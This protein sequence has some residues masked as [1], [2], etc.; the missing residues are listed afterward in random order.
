MQT[1]SNI[2]DVTVLDPRQKHPTIFRTFDGLAEG[3]S[4][5]I[6]ND[7]DPK[8][9]Y[10][11]M[12]NERGNSF[13]WEYQE[14]GPVWWK[15]K[16]TRSM[17]KAGDATVGELAAQ[18]LRKAEVFRK[19]GIDFCCGGKKT[20]NQVCEE[21]GLNVAAIEKEL[22]E[23]RKVSSQR[24]LN[25]NDWS[26]DFL[27]DYI[28]NTHHTY[29]KKA[30]PDL[31]SFAY[32]VAN[33]HGNNHPELIAIHHLVEDLNQE[34]TEHLFKEENI[35]FPYTRVLVAAK[36]GATVEPSCF[37]TVQSPIRVM[38]AEHDAAGEIMAKIRDLSGNYTI[39]A[40]ACASYSLL[41]RTLEEFETDL[42]MHIHLENNILFPK[43]IELEKKVML[44][45]SGKK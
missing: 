28:T 25:F 13:K 3:D 15:V 24:A 27:A 40:E 38:E 30:L 1:T 41:F 29:V 36:N 9:L 18:D 32:K 35:L 26:I 39:P 10:Y 17:E 2:L 43:A 31:R 21:K 5:V 23:N 19:Y 33:V 45:A 34:L 7:H 4:F 20:L 37:D 16:I 12:I 11:Q 8:P 44:A 42:H 14:E 6:H 22:Q